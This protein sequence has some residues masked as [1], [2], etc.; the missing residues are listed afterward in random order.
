[1]K[2]KFISMIFCLLL[3]TPAMSQ[4]AGLYGA[5]GV[6]AAWVSDSDVNVDGFFVGT[7]KFD[8]G[9][10]VGAAVGYMRE[11][12]R[13]EGELSYM[14]NDMD[15]FDGYPTS[16]EIDALTFL[17]NGYFDFNTGGPI[18]PYVTAGI[19]TS[20]IEI[21]EPGYPDEDDTVFV[22]QVGF[23]IGYELSNSLILDGRYR[24]MSG[25]NM[26]FSEGG[27][28]VEVEVASHNITVGVRIP[29]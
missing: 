7:A 5:V 2:K 26:E 9:Y 28:T 23:G 29:F 3:L 11:P 14:A 24:F 16:A 1:M 21:S 10:S 18:K 22:Y 15:T 20:R 13:L 25:Q 4:A 17:A 12:F 8:T 19:G 27:S 6:G